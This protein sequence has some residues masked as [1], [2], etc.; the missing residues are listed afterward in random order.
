MEVVLI[1]T[2]YINLYVGHDT[3]LMHI[4][5]SRNVPIFGIFS[6]RF[7]TFYPDKLIISTHSKKIL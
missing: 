1:S 2:D 6:N 3:G 5:A 4:A 7:H